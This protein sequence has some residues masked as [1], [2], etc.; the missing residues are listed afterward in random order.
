MRRY[1]TDV[2]RSYGYEVT[3]A[4]HAEE[5]L[6][7]CQG[8]TSRFDL[9]LADVMMAGMNGIDLVARLTTGQHAAKALLMSGF[10]EQNKTQT[11]IPRGAYLLPKPFSPERLAE[12]VQAILSAA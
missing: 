11:P 3:T 12:R 1:V 10:A 4:A 7:V 9:V 6:K 8:R 5:A 2:L